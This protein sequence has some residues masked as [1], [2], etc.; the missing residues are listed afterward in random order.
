MLTTA[1]AMQFYTGNYVEGVQG[2]AGAVYNQDSGIC[3][4][5]QVCAYPRGLSAVLWSL[6]LHPFPVVRDDCGLWCASCQNVCILRSNNEGV[7]QLRISCS[8]LEYAI[9]V[10]WSCRASQTQSTRRHSHP[11]C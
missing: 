10:Q 8:V 9:N 1:P 2:K 4:E 7:H 3:L 11:C 6:L 5:T